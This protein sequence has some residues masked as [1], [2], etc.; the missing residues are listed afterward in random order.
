M[1]VEDIAWPCELPEELKAKLLAMAVQCQGVKA[2]PFTVS[3]STL[4]GVYYVLKGSC[5]LCFSTNDSKSVLGAVVGTKDWFGA[6]NVGTGRKI[7]GVAEEIE[8]IHFLLFPEA[9]ILQL[10]KS[11]PLVYKWLFHAGI[12]AQSFIMQAMLSAIHQ[13]EQKV[14]YVLLELHSRQNQIGGATQSIN[15]SQT[16]LSSITGLS[17]SRLNE[18]LKG[19]EKKGLINIQR[20]K[21]FLLDI[22]ALSTLLSPMN[23]MMKN[24]TKNLD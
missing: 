5:G 16:Q 10:A 1:T 8:E 22:E 3:Y 14:M 17:R 24:P 18:V 11:E 2:L 21:I 4:P 19:L 6:L 15:A 9:K 13:K 12:H 7:F 23:L 20:G